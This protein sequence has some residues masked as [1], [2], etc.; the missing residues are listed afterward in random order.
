MVFD[1]T[2]YKRF[3]LLAMFQKKASENRK[4][5]AHVVYAKHFY[6]ML[7]YIAL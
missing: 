2:K 7:V 4:P 5:T 3:Y 6:N 1:N